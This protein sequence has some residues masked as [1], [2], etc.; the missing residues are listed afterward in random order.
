MKNST[1]KL[2]MLFVYLAIVVAVSFRVAVHPTHYTSPDSIAYLKKAE[3]ITQVW[4]SPNEPF[5]QIKGSFSM[6]PIGYPS[7]IALTSLLT[8]TSLLVSSKLVNFAF[9]ALIFL[10]LHHWFGRKSWFLALTFCSYGS[11]E[12]ISTTW[13]ELPFVFFVLLLCYLIDKSKDYSAY[14][15][16]IGL[17]LCF[18]CLFLYRY[19]GVIYFFIASVIVAK[20]FFRKEKKLAFAYI[21]ALFVSSIF[22][23]SYLYDNQISSG[24]YAGAPR[25]TI[26][27]QGI[28]QF[29]LFLLQGVF[30]EYSIARNYAFYQ[31]S[32]DFLFIFLLVLQSGV[33]LLLIKH[34]KHFKYPIKRTK[35]IDTLLIVGGGYLLGIIVLKAL[36][37][38]DRFDHRILFPFTA[39]LLIGLFAAFIAD[40]Q[41]VFFKKVSKAIV[42]F[43]LLSLVVNLPKKHLVSHV[44][45][46]LHITDYQ[47]SNE[48]QCVISKITSDRL[49]RKTAYLL[50][51]P[52][53]KPRNG[54]CIARRKWCR[55]IHLDTYACR[56]T[57]QYFG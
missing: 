5:Y 52:R 3:A 44:K 38:I 10:L 12:V 11:L 31:P 14:I 18:I 51:E 1:E 30:N 13:S 35:S 16:A 27:H 40:E 34:K 24:F 54:D 4:T 56:L 48:Y 2:L 25:L 26:G 57:P 22:V 39:P 32:T 28:G 42:L 36:I 50:P 23:L 53:I 46:F 7:S 45:Q 21:A 37:P 33:V 19:I 49:C 17:C 43:M 29:V 8:K 6:W 47:Q 20:H 55:E 9:L 15:L 41:A